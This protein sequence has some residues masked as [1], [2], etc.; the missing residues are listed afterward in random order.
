MHEALIV[1]EVALCARRGCPLLILQS[2]AR[3]KTI[4]LPLGAVE[5]CLVGCVLHEGGAGVERCVGLLAEALKE[6]NGELESVEFSRCPAGR[7]RAELVFRL[8]DG[9]ARRQW[10]RPADAATL[11]VAFGVPLSLTDRNRVTQERDDL[12]P[13]DVA[14][15][16]EDLSPEDF[17]GPEFSAEG[18]PP[19]E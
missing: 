15:W 10:C 8:P 3:D 4:S 18:G 14:R 11:A 9:E 2:L 16:L 6:A 5:A 17:S 19:T 13:S 1:K 12:D 7:W